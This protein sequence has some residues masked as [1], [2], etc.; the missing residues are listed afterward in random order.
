M[1]GYT[2]NIE[3]KTIQNEFYRKVLFTGKK[4]QLVVMSIRVGEDIPLETHPKT[5]Q[6]IR[7]EKGTAFVKIGEEE[8]TLNEDEIVIIPAGN[9]HYVKNASPTK[10]LKLYSLYAPPEHPDG[11]IHKTCKDAAKAEHH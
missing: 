3:N 10:V 7:I 6:F 4:I 5:D 9:P 11:T 2:T 1:T 8:H